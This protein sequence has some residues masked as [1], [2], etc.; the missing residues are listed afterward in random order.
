MSAQPN[1]LAILQELEPEAGWISTAR[2]SR[3]WST[4]ARSG[5]TFCHIRRRGS[6]FVAAVH[7]LR[8]VDFRGVDGIDLD[9]STAVRMALTGYRSVT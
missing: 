1:L 8:G 2:C 9:L 4:A 3:R 7:H 5:N 6:C